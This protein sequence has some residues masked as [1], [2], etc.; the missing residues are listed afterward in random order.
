[1]VLL[2]VF[3]TFHT[4]FFYLLINLISLKINLTAQVK[5]MIY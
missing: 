4:V 2:D 1:M 5:E 3:C